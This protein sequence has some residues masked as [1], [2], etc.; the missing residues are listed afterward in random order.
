MFSKKNKTI[1]DY[2]EGHEPYFEIETMAKP[3]YLEG[4]APPEHMELF[5]IME[6]YFDLL[7]PAVQDYI[8]SVAVVI[9]NMSKELAESRDNIENARR[10]LTFEQQNVSDY[11]DE[12]RGLKGELQNLFVIKRDLETR[13]E[14]ER[15]MLQAQFNEE[16]RALQLLADSGGG[17]V[18]MNA[19]MEK[20]KAGAGDSEEVKRLQKKVSTLEQQIKE[21]REENERIQGEL[22]MSFMEKAVKQDEI[23][24]NLKARLG[25]S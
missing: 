13:L 3:N 10:Q 17:S 22:S 8:N 19:L 7:H 16:K 20:M 4:T 6:E 15:E 25:T 12:I 24:Q 18:D 5:K 23:I 1:F 11:A 2:Y 21:E 9:N 14:D